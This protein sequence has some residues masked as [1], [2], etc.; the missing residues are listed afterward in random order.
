MIIIQPNWQL[1]LFSSVLSQH[2]NCLCITTRL[3]LEQKRKIYGYA[4]QQVRVQFLANEWT[5]NVIVH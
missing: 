1:L 4:V 5:M 3:T 2:F